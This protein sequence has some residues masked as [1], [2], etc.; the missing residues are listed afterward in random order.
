MV[1]TDTKTYD[2]VIMGAGFAGVCQAR[3]LLLNVPNIKI[4]LIDP[5]PEERTNKDLK[6]GE[7]MVEIATLFVCKELGLYEYMIENH[8]PKYALNFHWAKDADKTDTIDDYYHIWANRQFPLGTFQMNRAKFERDLL[9]MNKKMGAS[10]YQGRVVDVDITPTDEMHTVKVKMIDGNYHELRAK[11]LVDAAGRRFI[12]GH[13]T[14][15]V[16]VGADNLFGVDTGSAWVRVKNIDRTIFHDGYDPYGATCSHY[17]ATNHWFGHGHWL[18]MIPTEKDSQEISIGI[19]Q[20]RSVIAND[21]INTQEKFYAFLKANHNL[22]YRLVTSGENV[23]F[24]YLP[25]VSHTSK[26]MFSQD[27]WYVVG[28]SACIF[29]PFYSLGTSMI[30]FAIESITEIIRSQLAGEADTEEK[31]AAYNDFNLTYTRLN[32]HLIEHHDKQL[33]HASIMSWRI[34]AEYMWWFGIQIPL[35]VGKW[36]LDPGFISRYVPKVQADIKG[37]WHHLYE[38]FNQLVEQNKNI[39]FMDAHRTDQLIWGYHTLKHFDDF[40]ENTKFEP[41]RCNVFAGI[42]ATSFYTAVWYAKFLWKGFGFSAFLNP[43]NLSYLFGHLNG[44]VQSA[45]TEMVYKYLT[46]KLPDNSQ[47]EQTRQEF[48][49]YRYR[50]QL[51]PWLTETVTNSPKKVPVNV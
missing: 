7:S 24:H 49:N 17:Y 48:T 22:L 3:H 11:H 20:H 1:T 5:R 51:N 6:I 37:Y 31:R 34:Y 18:W 2:V 4:A 29:D 13:K 14:D 19:A 28:D 36:H 47:I 42:K 21:Q 38:Q 16:I 27:N 9:K 30:A 43:K 44:A 23:D 40:I 35:Y 41:R 39:G 50:P 46:R 45:I 26:T 15:N 8:P 33:G 10:F 32:N 25:R 12:I